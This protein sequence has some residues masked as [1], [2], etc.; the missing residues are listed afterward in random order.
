MMPNATADISGGRVLH[1]TFEVDAHFDGRRWCDMFVGAAG[2][3]LLLTGKFAENNQKPT[4]SG[5]LFRWKIRQE[6]HNAQMFLG[7][8]ETDVMGLPDWQSQQT[9]RRLYWDNVSPLANGTQQDLDKRHKFDLYLSQ[10][11][12]R[13]TETTPD[14]LYSVVR[15]T[16][17]PAGQ[18][19]PFTKAQVY[20][21]HQLYHT[22][23]DRNELVDYQPWEAY[24]HNLRPW[25]DE[26]HWDNMGFD[27][28]PAFPA[29]PDFAPLPR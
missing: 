14:G 9:V 24:W 27:V 2:D 29:L 13:I 10:T 28:L 12:F 16:D 3:P 25:C 4:A 21:V 17:L 23:N 1:A 19:L 26:R 18:S 8:H 22:G 7:G 5:N 15:D 11:H 6:T 20:F